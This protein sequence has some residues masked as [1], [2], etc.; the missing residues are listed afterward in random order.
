MHRVE[1]GV[2]RDRVRVSTNPEIQLSR[3]QKT[4][5]TASAREMIR[6]GLAYRALPIRAMALAS[7]GERGN[8]KILAVLEGAEPGVKFAEA[9]F[10][11][12]DARDRLVAQWTADGSE[13]ASAPVITA[14]EGT[15]GPYRLRVAAIDAH[16]RRGT[17]EYE[18]IA[19]L[20]DAAPLAMSALALGVSRDGGFSPKLVFGTD[21]AAVAY[22]EIYG[23]APKSDS[24]S[25]R[26]EIA[27][28]ADDRALTTAAP[29]VVAQGDERHIAIGALPI[30]AL[31]PGE[32]VVRAIVSVDG[33]PVG[34]VSRTL[35]KSPLGS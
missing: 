18:F 5:A 10:G 29:R 26:L 20:T 11:L 15:P 13:L 27:E 22:F 4:A 19:R 8:V 21:Q 35:R 2:S 6:N 30:A 14:G 34:R 28:G 32:Y 31:R 9:V 23:R 33:R 17:T 3:S 16:G 12:I 25:V 1:V 7:A 24:I